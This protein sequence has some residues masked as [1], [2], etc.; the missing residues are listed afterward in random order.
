MSEQKLKYK[1][2]YTSLKALDSTSSSTKLISR[3]FPYPEASEKTKISVYLCGSAGRLPLYIQKTIASQFHTQKNSILFVD[4]EGYD[5]PS[6]TPETTLQ[7]MHSIKD[8]REE[9]FQKF[10]QNHG[11]IRD[12]LIQALLNL[13]EYIGTKPKI[14]FLIGISMGAQPLYELAIKNGLG[15]EIQLL[16]LEAPFFTHEIILPLNDIK[17]TIPLIISLPG[18]E[19]LPQSAI[20]PGI[21]DS[22]DKQQQKIQQDR[23]L[24]C[25][26]GKS[27]SE[28]LNSK[29]EQFEQLQCDYTV[30]I[31]GNTSHV[32]F[33]AN[34]KIQE[35]NWKLYLQY[36]R[37]LKTK[38][39]K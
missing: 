4:Y 27:Y 24:D 17:P 1:E 32:S 31:L 10:T 36:F 29:L 20:T 18:K 16:L 33:L 11:Y 28:I 6:F 5:M 12:R 14:G 13:E 37:Y 25:F 22:S 38:H 30:F 34:P 8:V 15:Y 26:A 35:Y 2:F 21:N 3:F 19:F 7:T 23:F 9:L 39:R